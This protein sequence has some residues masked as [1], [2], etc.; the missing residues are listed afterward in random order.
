MNRR[1]NFKDTMNHITPE[2]IILDLGGNPLSSMEGD[3]QRELLDYLGYDN[4][5]NT[6]PD[7][8][9]SKRIDERI[10][11]Y[12][13]I[14]TRSVGEIIIPENSQ[15]KIISDN[16]YIDEWGIKRRFSGLYWDIVNHPLKNAS[17]EDLDSY[18][19]PD[20]NSIDSTKIAKITNMAKTLYNETNYIVCAA[21]PVY[22]VFELGC[23]LCGFD[24]FLIKIMID[25]DFVKK[26]FDIIL[27]YQKKV[28]DIYYE[29]LGKYIHYTSSGDDFA[30]QSSMFMSPDIFRSLIKP[31]LGERIKYTKKHTDS[32][33]L[34]HS[35]GNIYPIIDDLI[36]IGVDII[37]PI[38]PVS[39]EM[40]PTSL[41]STFNNEIVLH[42]GIDTQEILPYGNKE[43]ISEYVKER[44]DILNTNG[45]YI[46][47]A[48]HN[49]QEDVPPENICYMF[50]T[51]RKYGCK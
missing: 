30:T 44:I 14:D 7:F 6:R 23:W 51:A 19:W 13:D 47:A 18:F 21:H 50:E 41:K 45:G 33:F 37:N 39:N 26:L 9:G 22:G 38:Q 20:A 15:H 5:A 11:K 48:A 43:T 31:Y 24:D 35:C 2:N 40:S 16:E 10:L 36:D 3:S 34:H 4:K 25:Q 1:K 28:I 8:D 17:V 12:L 42:G 29:K 46:F 32:Y 49:I 27:D